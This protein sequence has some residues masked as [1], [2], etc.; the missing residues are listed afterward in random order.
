[1]ASVPSNLRAD[2]YHSNAPLFIMPETVEY[3]LRYLPLDKIK[4]I[5]SALG[6][7]LAV[8]RDNA[9][10]PFKEDPITI[11]SQRCNVEISRWFF[12]YG[13]RIGTKT[14]RVFDISSHRSMLTK[15]LENAD[16]AEAIWA[17]L[18]NWQRGNCLQDWSQF[19]AST[20]DLDLLKWCEPKMLEDEWWTQVINTAVASVQLSVAKYLA[21]KYNARADGSSITGLIE[22]GKLSD[23]DAVRPFVGG[24]VNRQ[25]LYE[26]ALDSCDLKTLEWVYNFAGKP[27]SFYL[28][29]CQDLYKKPL[30]VI[31]W[32]FR[33]NIATTKTDFDVVAKF[34]HAEMYNAIL[35]T[36]FP[37][38]HL[39]TDYFLSIA[40]REFNGEFIDYLLAHGVSSDRFASLALQ[41]GSIEIL[42]HIH[43]RGYEPNAEFRAMA[44][45]QGSHAVKAWLFDIS[46]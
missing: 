12:R 38:S 31:E 37:A 3:A 7:N 45:E 34:S 46:V 9:Y 36:G 35:S 2:L 41:S 33:K 8:K 21:D 32:I 6:D 17:I 26:S 14:V 18:E 10:L 15:D 13:V 19:A 28:K 5:Y 27:R 43:S 40:C 42:Q 25:A 39:F 30:D 44:R 20:G 22:R 4:K 29:N 23:L 16:A 11:V 1:M 24:H